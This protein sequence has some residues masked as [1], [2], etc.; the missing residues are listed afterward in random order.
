MSER[1]EHPI[2][3][4]WR[5]MK[6]R[7]YNPS[8]YNYHKYGGRGIKVCER[9]FNLYDNFYEDMFPTWKEGLQLD[10]IENNGNYEPG[11]CRWST[12][13]EQQLNRNPYNKT[14]VKGVKKHY[15][16]FIAELH[17]GK[18]KRY[19]G[20]FKTIEEANEAYQKARKE[21]GQENC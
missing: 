16:R 7:C 14:G 21:Y 18:I 2:Y 1:T 13:R 11:N 20:S 12:R 17:D 4:A 6:G 8:R 9:W 5:N 15:N 3:I 10:R 19:L